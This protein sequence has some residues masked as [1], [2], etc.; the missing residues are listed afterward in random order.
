MH[1]W[2]TKNPCAARVSEGQWQHMLPLGM[3]A[4]VPA[5][6]IRIGLDPRLMNKHQQLVH[7]NRSR[8]SASGPCALDGT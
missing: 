3:A 5:V 7:L 4:I 6:D 1:F 8:V 2:S